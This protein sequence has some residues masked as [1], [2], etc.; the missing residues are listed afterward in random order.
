MHQT[1]LY[2]FNSDENEDQTYNLLNIV[3][4]ILPYPKNT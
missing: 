3:N 1:V 4:I 2:V